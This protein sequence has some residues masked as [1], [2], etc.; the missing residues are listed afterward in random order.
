MRRLSESVTGPLIASFAEDKQGYGWALFAHSIG[1]LFG[2][3]M[4]WWAFQKYDE[5]DYVFFG[6]GLLFVYQTYRM[7]TRHKRP[8]IKIYEKGIWISWPSIFIKS[9]FFIWERVE[10]IEQKRFEY[11]L[12]PTVRFLPGYYINIKDHRGTFVSQ[13]VGGYTELYRLFNQYKVRNAN[14]PLYL[15]EVDV[16]GFVMKKSIFCSAVYYPDKNK[17]VNEKIQP[18]VY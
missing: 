15:F 3:G 12:S 7:A 4:T 1:L 16:W 13:T 5:F 14:K 10:K 17:L 9:K 11:Y 6:I 2:F 8:Y 18:V